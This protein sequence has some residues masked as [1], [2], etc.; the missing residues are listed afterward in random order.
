[1]RTATVR[2]PKCMPERWYRVTFRNGQTK[3]YRADSE[4]DARQKART[5]PVDVS[6]ATLDHP[7][8]DRCSARNPQGKQCLREPH[9]SFNISHKFD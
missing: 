6:H 3:M 4:A 8:K 9:D 5:F 2:M 1:M 7:R